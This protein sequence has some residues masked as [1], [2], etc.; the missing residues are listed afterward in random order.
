MNRQN[1][2]DETKAA[3]KLELKKLTLRE[4]TNV[5]GGCCTASHHCLVG[6]TI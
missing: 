5:T 3:K 6:D 2:K 1:K 4:L